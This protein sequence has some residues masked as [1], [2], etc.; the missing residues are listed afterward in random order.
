MTWGVGE[1]WERV[2][3]SLLRVVGLGCVLRLEEDLEEHCDAPRPGEKIGQAESAA[4][5]VCQQTGGTYFRNLQIQ[6][7]SS[8]PGTN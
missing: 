1:R 6:G 5:G 4:D 3:G 7:R 2:Q 8:L